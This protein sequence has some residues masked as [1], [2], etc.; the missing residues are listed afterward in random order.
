MTLSFQ[1]PPI[2]PSVT[3]ISKGNIFFQVRPI[4]PS[5]S[6]DPEDS[7]DDAQSDS[8]ETG[9]FIEHSHEVLF[10]PDTDRCRMRYSTKQVKDSGIFTMVRG[11]GG[12][13]GAIIFGRFGRGSELI[14]LCWEGGIL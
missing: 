5:D 6:E 9:D 3:R 11:V 12:G 1:V 14:C 2:F 10:F 13:G 7:E 4:V 8:S